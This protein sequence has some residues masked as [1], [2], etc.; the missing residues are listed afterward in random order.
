MPTN[1][2]SE[3]KSRLAVRT[4]HEQGAGPTIVPLPPAPARR[5]LHAAF[6]SPHVPPSDSHVAEPK[7]AAVMFTVTAGVELTCKRQTA[8]RCTRTQRARVHTALLYGCH[9][10][11]GLLMALA[12]PP[13]RH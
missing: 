5:C 10:G 1:P 8:D 12:G 9:C 2:C 4:A 3:V 7:A 11:D 13:T 6:A